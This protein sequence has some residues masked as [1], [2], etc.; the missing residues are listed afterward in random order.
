MVPRLSLVLGGDW[1]GTR[2]VL[3]YGRWVDRFTGADFSGGEVA[4]EELLAGFPVALLAREG[5]G[6]PA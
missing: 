6:D 5:G 2:C 3:P 4:L 1:A